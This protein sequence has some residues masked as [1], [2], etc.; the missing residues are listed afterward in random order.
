MAE[1]GGDHLTAISEL[2]RNIRD[3][4]HVFLVPSPQGASQLRK[5]MGC[6]IRCC[7]KAIDLFILQVQAGK[8]TCSTSCEERQVM[9]EVLASGTL[10]ALV[11]CLG[12]LDFE[13]QK[14]V[15][16]LF[17]ALVRLAASIG[18]DAQI[19]AYVDG[20][21][22]VL[23]SLLEGLTKTEL[24]LHCAQMLTSC[25]RSTELTPALLRG[26]VA[27]RLVELVKDPNFDIASEALAVLNELLLAQHAS[28]ASF[29]K[30]NFDEFFDS[31]HNL[32]EFQNYVVQRQILRLLHKMLM[33]K[34][35]PD[36]MLRYVA[37]EQFLQ[38]HMNLLLHNSKAMQLA[39]FHI[40]K[41]FAAIPGKSYRVQQILYRNK[42]KL[43]GL[44]GSFQP[45]A[46]D[47]AALARDL[48]FTLHNVTQLVSPGRNPLASMPKSAGLDAQQAKQP[49]SVRHGSSKPCSHTTAEGKPP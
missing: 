7:W 49:D 20:N 32:L 17:A 31:F 44:L 30:A 10:A 3:M 36:V 29:V 2:N 42:K 13:A 5:R 46:K 23:Q 39:A 37:K 28:A 40:F 14:D 18:M 47:D 15:T 16:R 26:G 33:H 38:I 9:A 22:E 35:F 8:M 6:N 21:P 1:M 24:A 43:L 48:Q 4:A 11:S 41:F 34:S 25:T 19:A 27:F 12:A 45:K